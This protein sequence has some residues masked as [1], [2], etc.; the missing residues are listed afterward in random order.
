MLSG[1]TAT[2]TLLAACSGTTVQSTPSTS[3]QMQSKVAGP[4]RQPEIFFNARYQDGGTT[5]IYGY[6]RPQF[7]KVVVGVRGTGYCSD[8]AG[9]V[10]IA[11]GDSA[12]YHLHHDGNLGSGLSVFNMTTWSCAVDPKTNALA[13]TTNLD[14]T[15]AIFANQRG[16]ATVYSTG[17]SDALYCAFDARGDVFV[18]GLDGTKGALAELPRG[19]RAFK[20]VKLPK[21]IA[22][23]YAL[24]WDGENLAVE[25]SQADGEITI[26]RLGVT[27]FRGVILGTT[28][29]LTNRR[30]SR[31]PG[32]EFW[33]E[34]HNILEGT[35]NVSFSHFSYL[36]FWRY[37]GGGQAFRVKRVPAEIGGLAVSD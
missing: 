7:I 18:D 26:Y 4:P 10:W 36:E 21:P 31:Y 13:V 2:M 9:G 19:G 37:P 33:I 27:S 8:R 25:A 28:H 29:L 35:G 3:Q 30:L 11:T 14:G 12:L 16:Y 24:Q 23:I 1:L 17:L 15:V 5:Y 20:M 34:G 6:P 32:T 22:G